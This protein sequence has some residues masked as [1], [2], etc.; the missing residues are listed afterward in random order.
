MVRDAV[1]VVAEGKVAVEAEQ[2]ANVAG[3]MAM[4]N[5]QVLILRAGLTGRLAANAAFAALLLQHSF[6]FGSGYAVLPPQCLVAMLQFLLGFAA[7]LLALFVTAVLAL[8]MDAIW[9][10]LIAR[11]GRDRE[12]LLAAR[13][14]F[15]AGLRTGMS[16]EDHGRIAK[17][18]DS[19]ALARSS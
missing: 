2:A 9:R 8:A 5:V 6:V 17:Q 19:L 16:R 11:K 14:K 13:A 15:H 10:M 18:F 7:P 12:N 1:S 3:F 4:V